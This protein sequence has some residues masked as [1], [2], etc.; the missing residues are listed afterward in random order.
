MKFRINKLL[1]WV[2]FWGA[3]VF[4]YSCTGNFKKEK[5]IDWEYY[6]GKAI[7]DETKVPQ[8]TLPDV[9]TFGD[10]NW[11]NQLMW[12][13][14]RRPEI[15]ELYNTEVYGKVPAWTRKTEFK[16]TKTIPNAV[17]GKAT[18]KEV[19]AT[20]INNGKKAEMKILVYIPN[21]G[22]KKHPLFLGLNF[23]GNHTVYNDEN[24]T[25]ANGYV[26]NKKAIGV[27]NHKA[28]EAKYGVMS[29][30]WQV[31]K[32]IGNGFGLAT[33]FYGDLDPDFDD[34]DQNG[35]HPLFYTEGQ[36]RPNADEWGSISAWAWGL[37]RAMDYFETDPNI[38]EGKVA[39]V[40]HSRLAKTALWAVAA[41]NRFALSVSNN[42]GSGGAALFRRKFGETIDASL[43]Y[44]PQWY[45]ENFR[46]YENREDS[47]PVDQHMLIAF[48]APRPVYIASAKED[49]W[50]D[51]KGEFLSAKH[52]TPVYHIFNKKGIEVD[53]MPKPGV[54]VQNSIGYHI[55]EGKHN[56]TEFDWEQ[57]IRFAQKHFSNEKKVALTFD[58]GPDDS[59]TPKI[60][61][62]L[63]R[64]NV[65]ATFFLVGNNVKK[66]PEVFKRI[67]SEGHLVGNHSMTH[68]HLSYLGSLD[69]VLLEL[70]STNTLFKSITGEDF[71]YF[72]PPYGHLT[73]EQ[74]NYLQ[75]NGFKRV[76][77]NID[78]QD[79]DVANITSENIINKINNQVF[80]GANILLHSTNA[81]SS[82]SE[83]EKN[84][85]N[86][87]AAL[88]VVIKSLRNKGYKFVTVD[89][90]SDKH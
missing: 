45:C 8:Y 68:P 80:D 35:I 69:S 83:K 10:E 34:G 53:S 15:M 14:K 43:A 56:I 79:W 38:D 28:S 76:M 77:W 81:N 44:A 74:S 88:P 73:I 46:K 24:I 5:S 9:M 19:T 39:V 31:E 48:I 55:R 13:E 49:T 82:A 66:H 59:W 72:R 17:N 1:Y 11:Q 30:R 3:V 75:E 42:S 33:I 6:F 70:T 86:T 18:M 41:D 60:L 36:N 27:E 40:G 23:F 58:D 25:P 61:D 32:L 84:K 22:E 16:V 67:H 12:L 21:N 52:A 26:I 7:T 20:F 89:K 29:S 65:K 47:L 54:S 4:F 50:A 37:S 64:E 63:K 57:Y 90:L 85:E 87:V 71:E 51:P 78:P 62:I 2:T